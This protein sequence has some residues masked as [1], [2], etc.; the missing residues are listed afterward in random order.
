M[1]MLEQVDAD[2]REPG[3]IAADGSYTITLHYAGSPADRFTVDAPGYTVEAPLNELTN[4]VV[5]A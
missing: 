1:V 5:R 3:R 4:G 2:R